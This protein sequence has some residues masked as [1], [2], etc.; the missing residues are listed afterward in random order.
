MVID[1]DVLTNLTTVAWALGRWLIWTHT[2]TKKNKLFHRLQTWAAIT[3]TAPQQPLAFQHNMNKEQL[4]R[5]WDLVSEHNT[6]RNKMKMRTGEGWGEPDGH[7][8]A[9][10]ALKAVVGLWL[11]WME[12]FSPLDIVW[13]K[14]YWYLMESQSLFEEYHLYPHRGLLSFHFGNLIC[15]FR[16]CFHFHCKIKIV[17]T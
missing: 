13:E 12:L 11:W 15:S 7:P 1:T 5:S 9:N 10:Q 4:G 6:E 3:P 17:E 8:E 14:T 2:H 16:C